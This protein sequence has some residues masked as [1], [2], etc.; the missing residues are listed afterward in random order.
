MK[1][2]KYVRNKRRT[3]RSAVWK[4]QLLKRRRKSAQGIPFGQYIRVHPCYG[5]H[6]A[7]VHDDE[8]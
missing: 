2:K 8:Y 5:K 1:R 6:E 7:E 4:Q 3:T